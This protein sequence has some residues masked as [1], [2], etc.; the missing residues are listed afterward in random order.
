MGTLS[1]RESQYVREGLQRLGLRSLRGYYMTA[2]WRRIRGKYL[3]RSCERCGHDP[4]RGRGRGLNLHHKTYARLGAEL[5]GDLVTLCVFC[6][7]YAHGLR[8]APGKRKA[9]KRAR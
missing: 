4:R 8:A 7:E 3:K 5:P 1:K 2:H 9:K 6:H